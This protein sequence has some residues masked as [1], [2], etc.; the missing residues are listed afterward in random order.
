[1][2]DPLD[3]NLN[4][5]KTKIRKNPFYE[6][7]MKN[8]FA[9][10]VRD[11][12]KNVARITE[13]KRRIDDFDLFEHDADE[14]AALEEYKSLE[15]QNER[16]RERLRTK[17]NIKLDIGSVYFKNNPGYL[18]RLNDDVSFPSPTVY[19]CSSGKQGIFNRTADGQTHFRETGN[20]VYCL[21]LIW[22]SLQHEDVQ[23]IATLP[24]PISVRYYYPP[25]GDFIERIM[26]KGIFNNGVECESSLTDGLQPRYEWASLVLGD[27]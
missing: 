15:R 13:G 12:P 5:D 8:G 4:L 22:Q 27:M 17:Y 21:L 19:D 20:D 18:F 16:Q 10:T 2:I 23:L 6:D 7:I 3:T 11:S 25:A 9:V 24:S 1:M 26:T 14:L